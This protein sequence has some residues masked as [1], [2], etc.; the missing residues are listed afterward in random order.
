MPFFVGLGGLVLS[1]CWDEPTAMLDLFLDDTTDVVWKEWPDALAAAWQDE[2]AREE[3]LK[4]AD[5]LAPSLR[6][7]AEAIRHAHLSSI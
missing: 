7:R 3:W 5:Q 1:P 2:S 6:Q 4:F